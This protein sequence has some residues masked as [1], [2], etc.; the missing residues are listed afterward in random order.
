M[1]EISRGRAAV[2]MIFAVHGAALGAFA[3]RIP[4]IRDQL[5]LDPVAL[6]AAL[7]APAISA[8]FTMP[9]SGRVTRWLGSRRAITL[10]SVLL[11]LTL[12]PPVLA[13]SLP[14]L[15]LAL[16]A[17]GAATGIADVAMNAGGVDV[18]RRHGRS[19]ISGLHG[20]WSVGGLFGSG[21][22]DYVRAVTETVERLRRDPAALSDAREA[23]LANAGRFPLSRTADLLREL[24]A[25]LTR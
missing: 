8:C 21:L 24:S 7:V 11:S 6:G 10:M 20:S 5:E 17:Y 23:G 18:E 19:I 4:W 3:T 2:T 13:T 22:G 25:E 12:I 9:M 1:N 15:W 16:L 14:L